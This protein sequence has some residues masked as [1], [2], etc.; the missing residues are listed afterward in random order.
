MPASVIAAVVAAEVTATVAA[1]AAF[2]WGLGALATSVISSAAG[3]LTSTGISYVLGGDGGGG[4]SS[5]EAASRA[6]SSATSFAYSAQKRTHVIRSTIANREI[7]YGRTVK[8]GPLVFAET[9]NN[10]KQLH[11]VLVLAAHEIDGVEEI[12]LGDKPLGTLN[13]NGYPTT[14]FYKLDT[15][16]RDVG[17]YVTMNA[18]GACV[19][20]HS[21][22]YYAPVSVG[23]VDGTDGTGADILTAMTDVSPSAPE[24]LLQYSRSGGTYNFFIGEDDAPTR[25]KISYKWKPTVVTDG[26]V[27]VR[28]HLGTAGQAAD[29][30]L[31]AKNIGWTADHKLSGVAYLY[32]VLNWSQEK[33]PQGIPNIKA[34]IRG[35]K[36]YDPRTSTTY[37]SENTALA[38]RDYI[39]HPHGVGATSSEIDEASFIAAA[40]ICDEPVTLAAGGTEP[41]YTCNGVVDLGM[42]PK[43]AIKQILSSAAGVLLWRQGVYSAQVGAYTA[44]TLPA[45]TADDLRGPIRVRPRASR[46]DL[47]NAVRGTFVD[48]TRYWQPNDFPPV[49][50]AT[51]ATQDGGDVIWRDIALPFTISGPTAQR[52]A[53]IML[54][55][56][57][58]GITVEMQ[59]KPTCFR[60]AVWETVQ[61]TLPQLGWAAKEFKVVSWAVADNGGVDLT[62]QEEAAA[63]YDWNSGLETVID[64]APDLLLPT[65]N[66]TTPPANFRLSSGV[67]QMVITN[68]G[69]V[70]L[71]VRATWD[72]PANEFVTAGGR[73]EI[74]WKLAADSD[75]L[76]GQTLDGALAEAFIE[77]ITG[78][79]A[80]DFRARFINV[81][82]VPSFWTMIYGYVGSAKDAPPSNVS[83]LA[84][85]PHVGLVLF[86]WSRV[87]DTDLAGYELRYNGVGNTDWDSASIITRTTRGTQITTGIV[88]PGSWT[89]LIKAVDTTGNVSAVAATSNAVIVNSN[90]AV[91]Q[92]YE[93]DYWETGALINCIVHGPTRDLIVKSQAASAEAAGWDTFSEAV[94]DAY[95]AASYQTPEFDLG[96]EGTVRAYTLVTSFLMPLE[97]GIASPDVKFKARDGAGATVIDWQGWDVGNV[98]ARYL[99][100][101]LEIDTAEGLIDVSAMQPT[102]DAEY[103]VEVGNSVAIAA[104][105]TAIA[106]SRPFFRTPSITVTPVGSGDYTAQVDSPTT[107]G[108]NAFIRTGATAVVGTANWQARGI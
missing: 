40:N 81:A 12:W 101:R 62:L 11:L 66:E 86:R 5:S 103:R 47:Y 14:G 61:V 96:I 98:T 108:F 30:E 102:A 13:A 42:L 72:D 33:F 107:A 94:V 24:S 83:S 105:G 89:F 56:S 23:R 44:P 97:Q 2:E 51:Y 20:S 31:V 85:Q 21:S 19:V 50:N 82:G 3:F 45:I 53:K 80:Y 71:R 67:P 87:A 55:K 92:R 38:A 4:S 65:L 37:W 17:E 16:P 22:E 35:K 36:L 99:T 68:D 27:K 69:T 46:Q 63:C 104:A 106:F 64:P 90:I 39:L 79:V 91:L 74:Q 48:P 6:Q 41:R 34:K 15:G 54:E 77:P 43:H 70:V 100:F 49:K 26:P 52:L 28:I 18:T 88:P 29:S 95:A 32:V 8:S 7:V 58:Q 9:T 1:V 93:P 59:C 57:R 60:I 84:A 10:N 78:G 75:W 73:V 76:P 25:F